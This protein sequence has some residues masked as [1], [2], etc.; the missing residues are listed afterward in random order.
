M[1]E[2]LLHEALTTPSPG[3]SAGV[4]VYPELA[5]EGAELPRVTYSRV[6]TAPANSLA[7]HSG[8]D[9]VAMQIDCWATTALGAATLAREVRQALVG[10]AFKPLITGESSAMEID[11]RIYRRTLDVACWDKSF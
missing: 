4:R 5:P 7:G 11:P 1:L 9:R 2:Q 8:L 10:A 3:T 6:S